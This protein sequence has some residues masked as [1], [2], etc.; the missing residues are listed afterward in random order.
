MFT[1]LCVGKNREKAETAGNYMF[2]W[3][4]YIW[5]AIHSKYMYYLGSYPLVMWRELVVDQLFDTDKNHMLAITDYITSQL[6]LMSFT[7]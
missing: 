1:F 7:D 2:A 3:H 4:S 5:Q 6:P